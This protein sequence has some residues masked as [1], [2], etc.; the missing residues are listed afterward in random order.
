MI[1]TEDKEYR[2]KIWDSL[3]HSADV[4]EDPN[5]IHQHELIP[6]V[7]KGVAARWAKHQGHVITDRQSALYFLRG[8]S[9]EAL[10][11]R[12]DTGLHVVHNGVLC[13]VDWWTGGRYHFNEIKSTTMSS[14]AAWELL[15]TGEFPLETPHK[16]ASWFKQCAI[17]CIAFGISKC[18][19]VVFFLHGEYAERRTKCPECSKPLEELAET[20]L[21]KVCSAC[22]YKSYKIDLRTYLLGFTQDE[23]QAVESD[24]FNVRQSEFRAARHAQTGAEIV[25][26]TTPTP[27]FICWSCEP[28][29]LIGCPF[30]GSNDY[31]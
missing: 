26:K 13:S 15:K 11:R 19:L 29:K 21:Y 4:E 10:I 9:A 23:L 18:R 22:A 25:T 24:V 14:R 7:R 6:C 8:H 1:I 28:G 12:S 20:R 3:T 5:L 31:A 17:Y 27:G 30:F 2:N 16:F